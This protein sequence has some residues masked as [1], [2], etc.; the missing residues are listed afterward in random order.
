M[1]KTLTGII[2]S[3]RMNKTVIVRVERK[4]RHPLYKKVLTKHKNFHAHYEKDDI[5]E[6]DVV[7]IKETKPI[8]KLKHFIVIEK[9]KK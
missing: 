7:V 1:S 3:T 4:F 8:S 9:L 5:H 6:G 2:T